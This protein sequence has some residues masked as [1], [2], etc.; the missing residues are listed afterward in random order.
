MAGML[1]HEPTPERERI[2]QLPLKFV[3]PLSGYSSL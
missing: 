3:D 1:D 2:R